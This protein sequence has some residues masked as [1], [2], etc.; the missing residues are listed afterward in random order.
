MKLKKVSFTFKRGFTLIELTV[1]MV[2]MTILVSA[3]ASVVFAAF[4]GVENIQ[5]QK[6]IVADGFFAVSNFAREFGQM[7]NAES[8]VMGSNT[9]IKF[10]HNLGETVVYE[11]TGGKLYR[12]VDNGSSRIL[13][14]SVDVS[15]SSFRYFQENNSELTNVPLSS[16]DRASVWMV[17]FLLKM[18]NSIKTIQFVRD[19]FPENLKLSS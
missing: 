17:E 2:L 13:A 14:N 4:R 3:V 12:K 16:S 6:E 9:K 10:S 5:N 19:V 18:D 1:S 7:T 11:L 15:A 8:L